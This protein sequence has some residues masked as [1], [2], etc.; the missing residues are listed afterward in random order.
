MSNA[1]RSLAG[2]QK[3]H[4]VAMLGVASSKTTIQLGAADEEAED[5]KKRGGYRCSRCN[6]PKKNHVWYVF[7]E[8]PCDV[9]STIYSRHV[10]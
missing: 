9:N 3:Q 10:F 5:K 8:V 1:S 7:D 2:N 4:S 6:I